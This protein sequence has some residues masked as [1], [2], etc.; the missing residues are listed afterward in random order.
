MC[1]TA[2]VNRTWGK[3]SV[4]SGGVLA[5]GT[6]AVAA[7]AAG[8]ALAASIVALEILWG[9]WVAYNVVWVVL[10][11]FHF[12]SLPD[13]CPCDPPQ[14]ANVATVRLMGWVATLVGCAIVA[15]TAALTK[16]H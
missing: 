5:V 11:G 14:R 8:G 4:T 1:Q 9:G 6:A 7:G 10:A 2:K 3:V 12:L 15:Y 16:I 13:V